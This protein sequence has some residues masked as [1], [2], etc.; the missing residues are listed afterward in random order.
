MRRDKQLR[1]IEY[2]CVIIFMN[3]FVVE[4]KVYTNSKKLFIYYVTVVISLCIK[5]YF[6]SKNKA[7]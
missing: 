4:K 1:C 6:D 3:R 2:I 5:I 7:M